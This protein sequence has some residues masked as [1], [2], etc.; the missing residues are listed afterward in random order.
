[1]SAPALLDVRRASSAEDPGHERKFVWPPLIL[2]IV[3]VWFVPMGTSLG[4]DETG[5]Y[6]VIEAGLRESFLRSDLWAGTSWISNIL[7]IAARNAGGDHEAILRLP[8]MLASLAS[9]YVLNLVGTRLAGQLAAAYACLVFVCLRDVIYVASVMRPYSLAILFVLSAMHFLIRWF[10]TG[11]LRYGALYAVTAAAT[12]HAHYL[13][14]TSVLV[15]LAYFLLRRRAAEPLRVRSV[16][17]AAAWAVAGALTMPLIPNGLALLSRQNMSSLYLG[18]PDLAALLSSIAPP[19]LLG[20]IV[21]GLLIAVLTGHGPFRQVRAVPADYWLLAAWVLIP[22]GVLFLISRFTSMHVFAERYYA[23]SAP[24]ISL[25]AGTLITAFGSVRV[26]LILATSVAVSAVVIFGVQERFMRGLYDYRGA[27]AAIRTY[28]TD[29]STPVLAAS[30]FTEAR[31]LSV[32]ADPRYRD[33][34]YEPMI[35]YATGGRLVRLPLVMQSGTERY[36]E[37]I[38]E[39]ELVGRDRF[40]LVGIDR[41]ATGEYVSWFQGRTGELGFRSRTLGNF[42]GIAVT[43]FERGERGRE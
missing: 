35:R 12:M 24:A 13:F 36:M 23:A 22:P 32:I 37:G 41:Y 39:R 33:V 26:R 15:H 34:L 1:M 21:L 42:E 8:S 19:T 7:M 31:E 40:L 29:D 30:G 4:L 10:D 5:N 43:V 20:S 17:L 11:R 9:L 25:A 6:W 2:A 28:V 14:A 3:M 27:S 18:P 16:G 38:V